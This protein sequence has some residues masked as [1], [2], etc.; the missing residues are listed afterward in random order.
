MDESGKVIEDWGSFGG[1]QNTIGTLKPSEGYNVNVSS[2]CTLIINETGS[3]S[4]EIQ[5]ELI[6]STHF[7]PAYKGNGTDHMNINLVNLA[8]SGIEDGDEIGI[9]DGGV[10]VGS[11]KISNQ[12]AIAIGALIV[13]R[14]SISIPVSATDAVEGKN[15]YT[16]GNPI[17]LKLFRNGKEYP[18]TIQPL[19]QSKTVFEKGN[20]LFAQVDIATGLE[21]LTTSETAKIN[22][23]PN[24]FSDV[25]TVEINLAADAQVQVEVMNQLGQPVKTITTKKQLTSG[26][27]RLTWNGRNSGNGEVAPGIYHVRIEIDDSVI[28]RKIVL[29][30]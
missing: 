14:N 17:T 29:S 27:N 5:P 24:P 22:C 25:V 16:K 7:I 1:W 18:L 21:G 19:N 23:Y 10:C 8:E 4:E 28:H 30:K 12:P 2:A 15:G 6:A 26:V 3:K 13:N 11:A 20:S 9:F